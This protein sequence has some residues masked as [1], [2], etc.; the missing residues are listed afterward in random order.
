MTGSFPA[1]VLLQG[2]LYAA[3]GTESPFL[4]SFLGERGLTSGEIGVA[5]AA[6]TLMRLAA[7]PVAGYL[8]DRYDAMRAVLGVAAAASG[9]IAFAYLVGYGFWPLLG[10]SVLH[11][12]AIAALAPLADA[13]A[14]GAAEREGTFSYGWVRGAG[15]AAFV[16]GTLVSG[17]LVARA[18]LASIIVSSGLLFL[19]MA[20][21]TARVPPAPARVGLPSLGLGGLGELLALKPFRRMLVVAALVIGS[22]ALND[23]FAVIRW[24]EAGIGPSAISLLW[25]EAVTSEVLVFVLAGPWLLARLGTARVAM[26]AAG[27]GVVR[28]AAMASTAAVPVLAAIQPLHGFTFALLHLAAMQLIARVVPERLSASAQTLYGTLGLG[29]A[30][31]VLTAA[32]GLLYGAFGAGAFWGMAA[33]CALALPLAAG[34]DGAIPGH[35]EA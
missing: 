12:S 2:S 7:G 8:A 4:P 23:G 15:S 17:L 11:A 6:G 16:L 20:V 1:F 29:V 21:A 33:L 34:L 27:L 22:H 31:A 9:L 25:S 30:S 3:Y 19:V 13:L 10:V 28:W 32:G 14:L 35:P 5:L 24:R 26:L 18:G